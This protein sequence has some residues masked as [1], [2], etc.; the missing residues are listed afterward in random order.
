MAEL[1]I[2]V[3]DVG[4]GDF[5][6]AETPFGHRLVIDCGRGNVVPSEFLSKVSTI[7]ELQI[8]HPHEDHFSDLAALA[9]KS[10]LSFLCPDTDVF[11]DEEIAWR[12]RDKAKVATLRAL[13]RNLPFNGAAVSVG[14]QFSRSVWAPPEHAINYDDPNTVS[15][16]TILSCGSFKMLFGADLT[17]TGWDALLTEPRFVTAIA[18]TTIYKVA[19]HGRK[20]GCSDR[21]F[22]KITPTLCVVSDKMIDSTNEDTECIQWYRDR[23]IGCE[24]IYADG[25]KKV[26]K[27]LTTRK[28]G[29]IFI[30]ADPLTWYCETQTNWK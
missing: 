4:H 7:H 12:T 17:E 14:Q 2:S 8:S 11:T 27:V 3:L 26:R 20:E 9:K 19:H 21:L 28:D 13:Q 25:S 30:A 6:Y 24:F 18:N 10:I 23:T 15:L 16:V 22:K 1:K 29:S 5:I